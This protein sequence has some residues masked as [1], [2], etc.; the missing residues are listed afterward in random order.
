MNK[1]VIVYGGTGFIG[2]QYMKMN[3]DAILVRRDHDII[4]DLDKD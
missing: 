1:Q 4:S 2:S 3:P